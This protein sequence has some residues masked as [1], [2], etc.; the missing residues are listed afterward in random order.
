MVACHQPR[1]LRVRGPPLPSPLP[2]SPPSL[3]PPPPSPPPPP[4]PPLPPPLRPRPP[5]PP[6]AAVFLYPNS[7]PNHDAARGGLRCRHPTPTGEHHTHSTSMGFVALFFFGLFAEGTRTHARIFQPH[8]S[9]YVNE[10]KYTARGTPSTALL[11][12]CTPL[13]DPPR[14]S[15]DNTSPPLKTP[16]HPLPMHVPRPVMTGGHRALW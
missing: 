3:P 4:P 5:R 7:I 6:T 15:S 10:H 12:Y 13:R 9:P 14:V 16:P 11:T 8:S 1:T 2:P